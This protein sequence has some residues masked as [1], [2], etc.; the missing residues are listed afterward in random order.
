MVT[1][2]KTNA[3]MAMDTA[4]AILKTLNSRKLEGESSEPGSHVWLSP[5]VTNCMARW[6]TTSSSR[7]L[8]KMVSRKNPRKKFPQVNDTHSKCSSLH[9]LH[10]YWEHTEMLLGRQTSMGGTGEQH[11]H[12]PASMKHM[13]PSDRS[14]VGGLGN[15]SAA[16]SCTHTNV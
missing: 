11:L 10:T 16:R 5:S 9:A 12:W 3:M 4:M 8:P 14:E 13:L 7:R 6:L 15:T 2:P 1:R